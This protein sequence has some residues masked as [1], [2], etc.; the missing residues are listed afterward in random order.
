MLARAEVLAWRSVA[1]WADENDV[2]QDLIITRA[3]FDIFED[4]WLSQR[5]AFRGGTA[6]HRL[7]LAPPARYSEDID[8]VQRIPERIGPTFDRLRERLGWI[9]R[10]RSD[11]GRQPKI[12]FGFEAGAGSASPARRRLK[13]EI[14]TM[15]H[16]GTVEPVAYR[17]EHE[18]LA[19]ACE[20]P[21]YSLEE[22]LG[23]KVRALYQRKKGRDLFDLWW[24]NTHRELDLEG[25]AVHFRRYMA[26]E[27]SDV[28]SAAQ[29]RAN[30]D[31]KAA[32]GV[33]EEVRPLLRTDVGYDATEALAW[34]EEAFLPL[35]G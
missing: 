14:N 4:P 29:L 31:A 2:E 30:L 24:A 12:S 23:T 9:G 19:R 16:F 8:L 20:I 27:G 22:L 35:L 34:L 1:R 18:V 26:E 25:V 3:I 33:F 13:I 32:T 6:L 21:T 7:H 28:P 10:P 5:L 17:V 11:I 15:E